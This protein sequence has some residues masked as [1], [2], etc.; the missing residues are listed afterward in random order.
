MDRSLRVSLWAVA[1]LVAACGGGGGS[2]GGSAPP[3]PPPPPPPPASG[4]NANMAWRNLLT[5]ATTH[6]WSVTGTASNG[7]AYT[8]TLA[9]AAA[10]GQAVFPVNGTAYSA[11]DITGTIGISNLGLQSSTSRSYYDPTTFVVAGTRTT[12]NSNAATCSTTT[13]SLAP[14]T[15]T[16]LGTSGAL[17]SLNDLDGCLPTSAVVGTSTTTWSVEA[18]GVVNLFCL[19]T[20]AS[21]YSESDCFEVS[22]DGTLGARA[23]ISLTQPT[24]TLV[25]K[26]Y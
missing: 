12:V 20:T 3:P 24:L 22:T 10:S 2:G 8:I 17:Q 14:P 18:D 16:A 1:A 26:N 13:A 21:T 11:G 15:A 4:F 23:R 9:S 6:L 5:G 7:N 19:N 25:A